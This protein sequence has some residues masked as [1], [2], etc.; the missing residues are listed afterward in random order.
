MAERQA[1]NVLDA[2]NIIKGL[3]TKEESAPVE[4]VPTETTEEP[5]ET[6]ESEEGLLTEETESPDETESYEAEETS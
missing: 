1:T 2:G 6:V 4:N 5:T 3:M